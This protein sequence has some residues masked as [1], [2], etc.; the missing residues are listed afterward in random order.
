MKYSKKQFKDSEAPERKK[1]ELIRLKELDTIF[2]SAINPLSFNEIKEKLIDAEVEGVVYNQ[3]KNDCIKL[4][5][6]FGT[7]IEIYKDKKNKKKYLFKYAK[8]TEPIFFN[9]QQHGDFKLLLENI[10]HFDQVFTNNL[11]SE[12]QKNFFIQE[13]NNPFVVYERNLDYENGDFQKKFSKLYESIKNKYVLDITYQPF[14]EEE[15]SFSF[16][17]QFIKQY[18]GRWFCFGKSE[19]KPEIELY[20]LPI[21]TRIIEM[22]KNEKIHYQ[23]L[24]KDFGIHDYFSDVIGVTVPSNVKTEN[25][26]LKVDNKTIK[27]IVSKPLPGQIGK[28]E[29]ID[30]HY[31]LVKLRLKPNFELERLLLSYGE[32][33]EVL[34]PNYLR[35]IIK[36]RIENSIKN[37]KH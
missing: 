7:E 5:H 37:Y 17:P 23:P 15:F 31:T 26:V 1:N 9:Y 18:N 13:N 12:K 25:I 27:Y 33:I 2:S 22:V 8:D 36:Q 32:K 30:E 4:Y 34:E 20:N 11:L 16:H 35:E 28:I 24:E 3:F 29:P 6:T 10:H 14:G 19:H 21:D